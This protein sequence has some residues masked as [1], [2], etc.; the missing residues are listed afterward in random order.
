MRPQGAKQMIAEQ[1]PGIDV[2]YFPGIPDVSELPSAYKDT[3]S[4]PRPI[5]RFGLAE[6]VYA[7]E[8]IATSWPATGSA[9]RHGG[10]K[11]TPGPC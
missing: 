1:A 6:V 11:G 9:T 2:R 10:R 4:V 7:V 5:K 3:A 8:P